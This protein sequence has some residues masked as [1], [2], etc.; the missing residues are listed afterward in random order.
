[1]YF[2]YFVVP[3]CLGFAFLCIHLIIKYGRWM[4]ELGEGSGKKI[5]QS[6]LT[7]KSVS[8]IREVFTECLVHK[9]IFKVNPLLGYMHMSLALGWFL[10]IVVGKFESLYFT[11]DVVNEFYYP[12]FFRFF[13]LHPHN[14]TVLAIFNGLMDCVV[15]YH[16]FRRLPGFAQTI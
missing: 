5:V 6:L 2:D 15:A 1:M 14:T 8:A 16:S 9:K 12:I 3:F 13:E 11:G 7:R 10:L 4:S